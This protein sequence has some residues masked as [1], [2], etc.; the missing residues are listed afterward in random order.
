MNRR[1]QKW[2]TV[3]WKQECCG[4]GFCFPLNTLLKVELQNLK[5]LKP[6]DVMEENYTEGGRIS[7]I[8]MCCAECKKRSL[9]LP[10]ECRDAKAIGSIYIAAMLSIHLASKAFSSNQKIAHIRLAWI[11]WWMRVP[12]RYRIAQG[13]A[14]IVL[15]WWCA[16]LTWEVQN[17]FRLTFLVWSR[18]GRASFA[19]W[20][21]ALNLQPRGA[22]LLAAS[23]FSALVRAPHMGVCLQNACMKTWSWKQVLV[24]L[25]L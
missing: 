6:Y 9:M 17:I 21:R 15:G 4:G 3:L 22:I 13:A 2:G 20:Q 18:W 11:S 8:C 5:L 7:C 14:R 24:C 16:Q 25:T 12:G 23:E 19:R 10:L 1:N